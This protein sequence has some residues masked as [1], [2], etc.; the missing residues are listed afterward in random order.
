MSD[1]MS[2]SATTDAVTRTEMKAHL[3]VSTTRDDAYIDTLTKTAT[4]YIEDRTSQ[5]LIRQTRTLKM[6]GFYDRRYVHEIDDSHYETCQRWTIVPPRGPLVS[7][8][9]ITYVASESGTTTTLA[10]SDYSVSAD[11]PGRI[12]EA[13]NA[14]WPAVRDQQNSVTVTYITGHSTTQ[15][16]VPES[17]RHAVKLLAGHWYRNREAVD[18]TQFAPM[19]MA[20]D[21]LLGEYTLEHYG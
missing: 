16:G 10:S 17:L 19:P 1:V 2:T 7:V 18:M 12:A 9:S 4:R 15:A 5:C 3:N 8:S 21:A 13:Y 11:N 14:T 6:R 20:V